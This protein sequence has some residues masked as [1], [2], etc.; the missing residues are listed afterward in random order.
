MEH[1]L[2]NMEVVSDN[3]LKHKLQNWDLSTENIV[4]PGSCVCDKDSGT[5]MK[6]VKFD[7]TLFLARVELAL[8]YHFLTPSLTYDHDVFK[9][10]YKLYRAQLTVPAIS[11]E[12]VCNV[13]LRTV[14]GL[15]NSQLLPV[16][17]PQTISKH[18]PL[19]LRKQYN[20]LKPHV[21]LNR[22]IK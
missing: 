7:S 9:D 4:P 15:C 1:R 14:P 8:I 5:P 10:K 17:F 12:C 19:N 3:T 22:L 13:A 16:Y 18:F 11:W 20:G 2:N 21:K 6:R